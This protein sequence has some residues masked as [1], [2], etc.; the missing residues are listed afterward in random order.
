MPGGVGYGVIRLGGPIRVRWCG[1]VSID[2]TKTLDGLLA[3]LYL[4]VF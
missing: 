1:V 4:C 2:V 3:D